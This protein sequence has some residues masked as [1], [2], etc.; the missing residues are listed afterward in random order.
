MASRHHRR[1]GDGEVTAPSEQSGPQQS[2]DGDLAVAS[3]RACAEFLAAGEGDD[4]ARELV[5][6]C[7]IQ[8]ALLMRQRAEARR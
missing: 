1:D 2:G 8:W 6:W 3:L 4:D 7:A 5:A